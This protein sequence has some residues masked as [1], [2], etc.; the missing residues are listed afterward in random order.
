MEPARWERM[1]LIFDSALNRDPDERE[2]FVAKACGED[3]VLCEEIRALLAAHDESGYSPHSASELGDISSD[4]TGLTP[5]AVLSGRY[6]II[7]FVARGG[8]GEVY[9]ANDLEL[10]TLIAIK[11]IRSKISSKP[12]TLERFKRE[13]QLA[14]RV[15]HANVCRIFDLGTHQSPA[16]EKITFLT[17]ELLSGETLAENLKRSGPINL[18]EARQLIF[19]MADGLAAAHAAGV[20]H[21]D[22]KSA[23]VILQ[24]AKGSGVTVKITDFGLARAAEGADVSLIGATAQQTIAGTPAYM[25]PEQIEGGTISPA[26]DIYALGV[27]MYEMFTGRLPFVDDNPWK[28][29]LRRLKEDAPPPRTFAPQLDAAWDKAINRCLQRDPA[30]RFR[31]ASEFR[32]AIGSQRLEDVPPSPL[33]SAWVAVIILALTTTGIYSVLH[34]RHF[35]DATALQESSSVRYGWQETS[36]PSD[37]P[38]PNV[39]VVSATDDP[40]QVLIFG[41]SFVRTWHPTESLLPLLATGLSP[42]ALAQCT[43]G[44]WLVQQDQRSL[45]PWDVGNQRPLPSISLPFQ[46]RSASCLDQH[47]SVWGFLVND[48]QSSRWVEFDLAAHQVRRTINLDDSYIEAS[49][50]P[51]KH[52]LALIGKDRI[53]IWDLEA[54]KESFRAEP[55]EPWFTNISSAWSESGRYF[56]AGFKKLAIYDIAGQGNVINTLGTEGWINDVGWI[57]DSGI[58]V[59]DDRGRF[60]WTADLAHGWQLQQAPA[61][62]GSYRTFWMPSQYRWLSIDSS[63]RAVAWAY[64]DPSS[65]LG[66]QVSQFEI[67]SIAVP[68]SGSEAAVSGKDSRISVVDLKQQKVIRTLDGNTDGVPFV[69]YY[70]RQ[71]ISAGDDNTVRSWDP[72]TGK[73]LQTARGHTSLVNAFD[74]SSDGKWLV[75]VSSDNKVKL[76]KLPDLQFVKDIGETQDSGA[77][78]AFLRGDDSQFLVSDWKGKVYFYG[79]NPATWTLR[80]TLKLS[81][82]V[83]YMVCSS[84]QGWWAS[85]P[86]GNGAGLWTIPAGDFSTPKLFSRSPSWYCANSEDGKQTAVRFSNR[87]EVMSNQDQGVMATF[88]FAAEDGG[89]VA[90][91]QNLSMVLAA[92]D[93]G[94]ILTWPLGHGH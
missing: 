1:K 45:T 73:L 50:S 90:I 77:A 36:V 69:R 41:P 92:M 24:P 72:S 17:M 71:L 34:H 78:V 44:V 23:N 68:G 80:K 85:V 4:A 89:A 32:Q 53:A 11:L 25:A 76:W 91:D 59:I 46:F 93:H 7:R 28:A 21:R 9:A 37:L 94:R 75:S 42:V 54:G 67:W 2:S 83:V 82:Q 51:D 66:L 12:G 35:G 84:S 79:G 15:T 63:G 65:L 58:S 62:E 31:D 47:A 29:A 3:V 60:Y 19:E 88:R 22:F 26:T 61:S 14:R 20:V 33:R 30:R 40:S 13:V 87:V 81:D 39:T 18:P 49:V 74:V 8:M 64:H 16:G 56:A 27:V 70:N 48:G 52:H 10:H 5:G 86:E 43:S 57:G 38:M 6:Q 55:P